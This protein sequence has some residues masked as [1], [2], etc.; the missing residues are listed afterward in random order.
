[1]QRRPDGSYI[2]KTGISVIYLAGGCFWGLEKAFAGIH[3]VTDTECGYANGRGGAVPDYATVCS[4]RFGYKEAVRVEYD[5]RV[6]G[7]ERLLF[8][9]FS[10]IDPGSA[11]RQGNDRGVQY[12]TGVYW[13]DEDSAAAVVSYVD[14]ERL[15]HKVFRTE[16]GP[17]E[18]FFPAEPEH[19]DYLDRNPGG[20]CHIPWEMIRD[21]RRL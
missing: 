17:L 9:F 3:G 20:Y 8:A 19:Q 21:L 10:V 4:G 5:S 18:N 1:M 13:I 6:I 11:D 16:I 7:L 14:A 15:R 2:P 12:G